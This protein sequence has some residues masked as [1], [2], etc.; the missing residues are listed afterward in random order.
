MDLGLGTLLGGVLSSGGSIIANAQQQHMMHEQM[1]WQENMANTSYQRQSKDLM[2]AGL[3]PILALTKGGAETPSVNQPS[4]QNPLSGLGAGV[5]GAAAMKLD[6]QRYETEK[7]TALANIRNANSM[8]DKNSADALLSGKTGTLRDAELATQMAQTEYL[9]QQL[10]TGKSQENVNRAQEEVL[11]STK[12]QA[13]VMTN[14]YRNLYRLGDELLKRITGKSF[15][16]IT[17]A[18]VS[19]NVDKLA[20][21]LKDKMP[22]FKIPDALK[23]AEQT[24]NRWGERFRS[25]GEAVS[26]G[27]KNF[28]GGMNSA[29]GVSAGELSNKN[30][31]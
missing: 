26:T 22:G 28:Y 12:G 27:W 31:R 20:A 7:E 3:N 5:S 15:N 19:A 11:R 14:I 1:R 8:A 17:A 6:Q 2:A 16:N 4:L 25:A 10:N 9:K 21:A 23:D 29:K 18:D 24:W 13:E 30:L